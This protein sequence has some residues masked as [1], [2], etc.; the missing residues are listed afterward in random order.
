[1]SAKANLLIEQGTDYTTTLTVNDADGVPVNLTGYTGAAQIRKHYS[2]NTATTIAVSFSSDRT[3]GLVTLTV[4]RSVT[5][6]MA[7]GRYVY[8]VEL[9]NASA[10]VSRLV[11]G[12][13]TITPEVT[14]TTAFVTS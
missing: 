5:Q 4:A 8:D 9:T 12:I 6:A 1:M 3:S 10:S 11:E 14:R 7:H 2:S 13:V